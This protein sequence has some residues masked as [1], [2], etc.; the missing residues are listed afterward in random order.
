[1]KWISKPMAFVSE[2]RAELRKV[3]FPSK[4]ELTGTT[5]VVLVASFIFAFYLWLADLVI[6]RIYEGLF[7]VFGS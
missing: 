7:R 5:I 4:Q 6:I 3:T 2:T 1:M